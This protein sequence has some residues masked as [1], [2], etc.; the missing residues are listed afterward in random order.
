[1]KR[2]DEI[3][4]VLENLDSY[5]VVS[6]WNRYCEENS[7]YD[8]MVYPMYEFDDLMYGLKPS[9]IVAKLDSSFDIND[10]FFTWDSYGEVVSFNYISDSSIDLDD[11]ADY[12]DE[13]EEDFDIDE[14]KEIFNDED[15]EDE[16]NLENPAA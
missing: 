7:Y 4:E 1:M 8:D 12:M 13:H 11:L 15:D 10:D 5:E 14:I 3:R 2:Y 9:E 16:E 6:A